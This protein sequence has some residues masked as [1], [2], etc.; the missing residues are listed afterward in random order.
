[1]WTLAFSLEWSGHPQLMCVPASPTEIRGEFVLVF[2][3]FLPWGESNA[4]LGIKLSIED[5]LCTQENY[6][7]PLQVQLDGS[8]KDLFLLDLHLH[9]GIHAR[10]SVVPE[11][12]QAYGK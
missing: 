8:Q 7:W 1:M 12:F 2:S 4:F 10:L 9:R 5:S 3:I 6:K 11:V